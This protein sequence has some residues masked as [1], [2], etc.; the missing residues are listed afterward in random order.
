MIK[1]VVVVVVTVSYDW[2]E[3]MLAIQFLLIFVLEFKIGHALE[4]LFRNER[5]S[6]RGSILKEC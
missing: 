5:G 2:C 6:S 1:I 3:S 4:D